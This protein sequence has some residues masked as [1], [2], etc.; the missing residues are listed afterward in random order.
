MART[1]EDLE[2]DAARL[3]HQ[4]EAGGRAP[5]EQVEAAL[6]HVFRAYADVHRD[7]VD[8]AEGGDVEALKRAV[9]LQWFEVVEPPFLT[10]LSGLHDSAASRL[11]A[12]LE[13]RCAD[14]GID[15]ELGW[16]LPYY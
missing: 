15:D 9:F 12:L 13:R 14:G 8:L 3:L 5:R 4:V 1:L 16:M 11:M 10:G 7:Y 6:P 2:A